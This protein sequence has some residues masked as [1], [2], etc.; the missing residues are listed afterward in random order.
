MN[1]YNVIN[2]EFERIIDCRSYTNK[3]LLLLNRI[4]ERYNFRATRDSA[5]WDL[6]LTR[7]VNLLECLKD[8]PIDPLKLP[9]STTNP[10]SFI[11]VTI[12]MSPHNFIALNNERGLSMTAFVRVNW[13]DTR[14]IW[15]IQI[16]DEW[17]NSQ[18]DVPKKVNL[19]ANEIWH[20]VIWLDRCA[21]DSC[22]ITPSNS[23][24]IT[25]TRDGDVSFVITKKLDFLCDQN[26]Q[27]FP[28]DVMKCS[29]RFYSFE[30]SL[31]F[32]LPV[33]TSTPIRQF[34]P[35]EA[36]F[37]LNL[38]TPASIVESSELKAT[39]RMDSLSLP[40]QM[41]EW[42]LYMNRSF[43]TYILDTTGSAFEDIKYPAI[44][45]VYYFKR[46]PSHYMANLMMPLIIITILG[47]FLIFLPPGSEIKL[48]YSIALLIGFIFLQSIIAQIIPRS[49][50]MPQ[51]LVYL[52][53]SLILAASNVGIAAIIMKLRMITC[54][55]VPPRWLTFLTF[56]L[57]GVLVCSKHS[58]S[59]SWYYQKECKK[60][61]KKKLPTSA[62]EL[63]SGKQMADKESA[64]TEKGEGAL[65]P[66]IELISS[67]NEIEDQPPITVEAKGIVGG[68]VESAI[69]MKV[70]QG[71]EAVKKENK[72]WHQ[73][74]CVFD[75]FLCFFYV[76]ASLLNFFLLVL[77]LR[78]SSSNGEEKE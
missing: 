43:S 15:S 33:K 8:H 67:H 1:L 72:E 46:D 4:T 73:I 47:V 68:V 32:L 56:Q 70:E 13:K 21:C 55:K 75:R 41:H 42:I 64:K 5:V 25:L 30:R 19:H 59:C 61:E 6:L 10:F 39:A 29:G 26:F 34:P 22:I 71:K 44:E 50:G 17:R 36:E 37:L 51:I 14:R 18:I 58:I 54:P 40:I 23:T 76:I 27:N 69:K 7:G 20:P 74:A 78:Y 12:N 24:G 16:K 9:I 63:L 66:K 45:Y 11:T 49:A 77:Q 28:F 60:N 65:C 3:T 35:F 2:I 52:V 48:N 57:I 53:K 62:P 31:R 38:D